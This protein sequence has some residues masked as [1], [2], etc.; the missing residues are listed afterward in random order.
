MYALT[1]GDDAA[2]VIKTSDN[3]KAEAL[4]SEEYEIL[5]ASKVYNM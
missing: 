3:E 2:I 5:G 1:S 4:I